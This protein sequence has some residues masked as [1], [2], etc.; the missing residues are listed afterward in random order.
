MN[1]I[2]PNSLVADLFDS[3]TLI[4]RLTQLFDCTAIVIARERR[5]GAFLYHLAVE[6][7]S[8]SRYTAVRLIQGVFTEVAGNLT[9]KFEKSWPSLCHFLTSGEREIKEVWGRYAKDQII[10]I[11]DLKRRKKR[12]LGDP[13]IA[14]SAPVP[15]VKKLS[16]PFSRACPPFSTSL[17]EVGVGERKAHSINYH[18]VS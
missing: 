11:A 9:V 4:P 5:D 16:S 2:T 12:N 10:E 17:P 13:E 3:S 6:N 8:A 7:K 18:A 14:E 15:K 1:V